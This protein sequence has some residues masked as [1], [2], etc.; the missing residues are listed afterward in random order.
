MKVKELIKQLQELDSECEVIMAKDSEGNSYTPLSGFWTGA[1]VPDSTYS[2]EVYYA[3]FEGDPDPLDVRIP[4]K[5]EGA[6]Y[7][8]ILTP[9]W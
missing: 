8:I 9:T 1:Y 6:V 4:G 7:A 2:G 3:S 5:D